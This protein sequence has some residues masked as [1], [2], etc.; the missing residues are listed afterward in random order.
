MRV[1]PI[2]S[3]AANCCG[4]ALKTASAEPK[5]CSNFLATMSPTPSTRWRASRKINLDWSCFYFKIL[6]YR[7]KLN[8][9]KPKTSSKSIFSEESN[10]TIADSNVISN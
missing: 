5:C 10:G 8:R 9:N 4:F 1:A 3:M 7:K 2:P 6:A